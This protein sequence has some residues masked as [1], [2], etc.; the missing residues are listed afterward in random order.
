MPLGPTRP[1]AD[2]SLALGDVSKFVSKREAIFH[3]IT[4]PVPRRWSQTA[5]AVI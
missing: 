5:K 3:I 1:D 4:Y 2:G